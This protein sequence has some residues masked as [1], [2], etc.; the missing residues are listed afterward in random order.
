MNDASYVASRFL[1][2]SHQDDGAIVLHCARTGAIGVVPPTDADAARTALLPGTITNGP[3]TGILSDLEKGGFLVRQGTDEAA[4][5]HEDYIARYVDPNLHLI[6]LPTEQCNFRCVY[7]YESFL[8]GTMGP[9]LQSGLRTFVQHQPSLKHFSLSWFGGEPLV[10][11][12]VVLE[13]TRYFKQYCDESGVEFICA[14]T[15]N[16]YLLTPEYADQVIPQMRRLRSD[17]WAEATAARASTPAAT[18][19]SVMPAG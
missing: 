5:V 4:Q 2:L 12:D 6:V 3:L 17:Y 13:N 15:T 9:E 19:L 8:R 10:A 16:A 11:R 18:N 7:C 14:A 1:S